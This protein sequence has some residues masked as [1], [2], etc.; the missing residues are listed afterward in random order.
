MELAIYLDL[1]VKSTA[2]LVTSIEHNGICFFLPGKCAGDY[3]SNLAATCNILC[4]IAFA[5]NPKEPLSDGDH[6]FV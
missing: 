6:G 5:G 2:C 3:G 1:T 4:G